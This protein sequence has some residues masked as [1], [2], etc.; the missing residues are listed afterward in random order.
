[1]RK[2][3]VPFSCAVIIIICCAL[4]GG[5]PTAQESENYRGL[6][7]LAYR[8]MAS[9]YLDPENLDLEIALIYLHTS[10]LHQ[11]RGGSTL[12]N[13]AYV[14]K[15]QGHLEL[16]KNTFLAATSKARF[17]KV[18]LSFN[19]LG[20]IYAEQDSMGKAVFCWRTAMKIAP[21]NYMAPYN[22]AT[23]L[24]ATGDKEEARKVLRPFYDTPLAR[25]EVVK[26]MEGI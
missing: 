15:L 7:A 14:Y 3:W 2:Y 16:A 13:I 21:G 4:D 11:R 25:P 12:H 20:N 18:Y 10:Y 8:G 1:M 19:S 23:Y 6:R 9:H 22:Y 24:V 17:K 5:V 26:L